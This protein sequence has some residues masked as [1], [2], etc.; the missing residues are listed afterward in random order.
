MNEQGTELKTRHSFGDFLYWNLIVSV[1]FI[2]ACIA[3]ARDSIVWLVF[4]IITCVLLVMVIYRFFCTHCTH[5][6]QGTKT[7]KCMFFWGVPK[8]FKEKPGPLSLLEKSVALLTPLVVTLL[9]LYYLLLQPGL[10][11]IYFLSVIVLC[12][13]LRRYECKRCIYSQCPANCV[14]EDLE[15]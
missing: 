11:V 3:I 2:T 6:L 13:T 9:P 10:L 8:F 14:K 12:T 4:Y 7:T 5:Y 15:I 1:P